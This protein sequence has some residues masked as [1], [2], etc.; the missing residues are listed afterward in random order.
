MRQISRIAF[1]AL[2]REGFTKEI[3]SW[4]CSIVSSVESL[5][6]R[7]QSF[8]ILSKLSEGGSALIRLY[9]DTWTDYLN[10]GETVKAGALYAHNFSNQELHEMLS[11]ARLLELRSLCMVSAEFG[12]HD[13][14]T[15][16][17]DSLSEKILEEMYTLADKLLTAA[18][19]DIKVHSKV[20]DIF[21]KAELPKPRAEIKSAFTSNGLRKEIAS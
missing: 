6:Q 14:F 1:A 5:S 9:F 7:N 2:I 4:E 15:S 11:D 10:A 12:D 8:E 16:R 20:S 17:A 21:L 3:F 18:G 13:V 19:Q